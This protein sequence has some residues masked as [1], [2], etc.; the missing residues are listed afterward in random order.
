MGSKE[1]SVSTAKSKVVERKVSLPTRWIK[2]LTSV[3]LFLAGMEERFRLNKI[4]I[5]PLF[6]SIPKTAVKSNFYLS[7]RANKFVFSPNPN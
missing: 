5:I 4:Q 1:V 3:Q 6:Q 2:G 7:K